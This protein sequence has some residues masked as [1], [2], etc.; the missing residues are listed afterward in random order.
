MRTEV[1]N[2][3]RRLQELE[4]LVFRIARVVGCGQAELKEIGPKDAFTR[5]LRED[6]L[7][8][9]GRVANLEFTA[10]RL[11]SYFK[12]YAG[13]RRDRDVA[14][15]NRADSI[16]EGIQEVEQRLDFVELAAFPTARQTVSKAIGPLTLGPS[17]KSDQLDR[18]DLNPRQK[19]KG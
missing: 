13:G 10:I 11:N 15:L 7:Q 8:L 17:D 12:R 9:D 16:S 6:V 2:L 5:L 1:G 19:R 4:N 18:R 14:L 3:E